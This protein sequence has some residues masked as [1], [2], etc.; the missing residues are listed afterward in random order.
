MLKVLPEI[1]ENS[2]QNQTVFPQT[3]PKLGKQ[4]LSCQGIHL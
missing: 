3:M 4:V 1:F 2:L